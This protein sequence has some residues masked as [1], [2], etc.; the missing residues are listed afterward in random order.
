MTRLKIG[1]MLVALVA[2][3]AVAHASNYALEEIPQVIPAADAAKL[4][5]QGIGTT[6]QLLEKAGEPK[7]RRE[8]ARAVKIPEKTL[9]GWVQMA[10]VMR[11]KGVGPDVTRLLAACG[12]HTV[13]QL[14][15]QDATKLNDEITKVNS[16]SHLSENPPSVEHLQAWIAQAQTLPIVLH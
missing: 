2:L 13:A 11:V 4:K 3:A 15:T 16:K 5:N 7:A 6:F 14:K 8:L 10:D 12:V 1:T 9:D